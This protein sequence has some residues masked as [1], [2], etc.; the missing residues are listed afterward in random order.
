MGRYPF[1]Y[2][3]LYRYSERNKIA[4]GYE[5]NGVKAG[6]VFLIALTQI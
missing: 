6:G 1:L 5:M 3:R 2:A 4:G